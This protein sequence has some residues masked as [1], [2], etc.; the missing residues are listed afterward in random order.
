MKKKKTEDEEIYRRRAGLLFAL[1]G[2]RSISEAST[3]WT[4]NAGLID[5]L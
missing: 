3:G 1:A 5:G 2:R 4:Y